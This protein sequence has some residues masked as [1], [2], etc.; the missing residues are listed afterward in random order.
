MGN[1]T[2]IALKLCN[3]VKCPRA[4]RLSPTHAHRRRSVEAQP[5]TRYN[6]VSREKT[7]LVH[8]LRRHG[9]L[10]QDDADAPARG[11]AARARTHRPR[12]DRTRRPS[13]FDEDSPHPARL[14]ESGTLLR[15]GVAVVLCFASAE[16][17][18]VDPAG[19]GSR[20]SG[21]I[22]PL[23][24]FFAGISGVWPRVGK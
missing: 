17:G 12:D 9:W 8:H 23:H 2:L 6:M 13:H 11:A 4:E 22:R 21:G 7:W 19:A 24:G 16:C 5:L 14:R 10:G 15:G 20:R 3:W 1:T 18:G